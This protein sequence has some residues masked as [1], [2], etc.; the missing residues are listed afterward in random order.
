VTTVLAGL[1]VA[2]ALVVMLRADLT[3]QREGKIL[4][5]LALLLL[6]SLTLWA[7]ASAHM[8]RATTTDFCLSC[9]TMED[10]G[11]SLR[12]EDKSYLPA[13]HFLNNRIP[14]ENACYTCH[15]QYTMFGDVNSKW[16]GLRHVYAQ[17]LGTIPKRGEIRL[18]EPFHNRECLHCHAGARSLLEASAH[19]K[20]PDLL[21]KT[22]RNEL[23]CVS[24]G[25]HDIIH[26]VT[27]LDDAKIWKAK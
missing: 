14:R 13:S 24:S 27:S 26:D 11:R 23:S 6:P 4:A 18:Y 9:H 22:E 15:T 2:L 7:G 25:C 5:F 1:T 8:E 16:R 19:Q 20:T 12:L 3:R 10:Y 21:A 17:Y